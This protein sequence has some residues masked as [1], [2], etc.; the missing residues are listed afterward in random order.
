MSTVSLTSIS[1]ASDDEIA[2]MKT[3]VEA[4]L[5]F[6]R[7]MLYIARIGDALVV[8]RQLRGPDAPEAGDLEN[9]LRMHL[10]KRLWPQQ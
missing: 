6:A 10:V 2:L 7:L 8:V 4:R 3:E 5:V 1:G 9:Q